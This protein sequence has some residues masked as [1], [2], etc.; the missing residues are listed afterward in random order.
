MAPRVGASRRI[1]APRLG[2]GIPLSIPFYLGANNLIIGKRLLAPRVGASKK[3]Y[4][5]RLENRIFLSFLL[6]YYIIGNKL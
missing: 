3:I 1:L 2:N 6:L 4:A 5:P